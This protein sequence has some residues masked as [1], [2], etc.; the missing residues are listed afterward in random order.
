LVKWEQLDPVDGGGAGGVHGG[1]RLVREYFRGHGHP[2]HLRDGDLV[3][4]SVGYIHGVASTST[5]INI[6]LPGGTLAGD[7]SVG[8]GWQLVG[9]AVLPT[10]YTALDGPTASDSA[11]IRSWYK[12]LDATDITNGYTTMPGDPGFNGCPY[13]IWIWHSTNGNPFV[14]GHSVRQASDLT[15]PTVFDSGT[16]NTVNANTG[17]CVGLGGRAGSGPTAWSST[18]GGVT[19]DQNS[20]SSGAGFMHL[21]AWHYSFA[22]PGTTSNQT[23][24]LDSNLDREHCGVIGVAEPA[25][26]A[27]QPFIRQAA[28]MVTPR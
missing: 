9:S 26:A 13:S 28:T 14:D 10:G 22:G 17:I 18:P 6:T 20:P 15:N 8:F 24:S 7:L 11:E 21:I 23:A 4:L 5:D 16:I 1:G 2:G 27:G 19:I 25:G 3:T 12:T